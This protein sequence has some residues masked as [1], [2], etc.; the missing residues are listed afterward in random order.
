[1]SETTDANVDV[2]EEI[3]VL[4][5]FIVFQFDEAID[6]NNRNA[7][8]ETR[9]SGIILHSNVIE[10][11]KHPR[12]GTVRAIGPKVDKDITVGTRILVAPLMW[13][14]VSNYKG[15]RFARTEVEHVLA[16][17]E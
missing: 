2:F 1:M 17:E 8:H 4:E 12:W 3:E 14:K 13:T 10:S 5:S 15:E 16:V 6:P 7:F 11:S 9:E